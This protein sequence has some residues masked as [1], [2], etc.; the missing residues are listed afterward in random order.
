M[1][2]ASVLGD[3]STGHGCYP[4]RPNSEASPNVTFGGKPAHRQGD[5]WQTHCCVDDPHPCHGGAAQGHSATVT[6][7]GKGAAR[8]GDSI[9]C[10]DT[11]QGP[12]VPSITIGG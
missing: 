5:A 3:V 2:V 6:I 7:N 10:G 8:I 4:S 9:S 1:P 11:I 12:G